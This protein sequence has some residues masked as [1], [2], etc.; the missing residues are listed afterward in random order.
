MAAAPYG[1]Q[2]PAYTLARLWYLIKHCPWDGVF[3]FD[4]CLSVYWQ[5]TGL[6]ALNMYIQR[7]VSTMDK[8]VL[9]ALK[10]LTMLGSIFLLLNHGR[11]IVSILTPVLLAIL[12]TLLLMP[13]VDYLEKKVKSRL[14]ATSIVLIPAFSAI[15]G[16][17]WWVTRMVYLEIEGFV[18]TFPTLVPA[19]QKLFNERVL[20]LVQGTRYEETFFV[21]LNEVIMR[22]IESLQAVAMRLISSGLSFIGSLPG[23]FVALMVTIILVVYLIYDKHWII[24]VAPGVGASIEKVITSIHGFIKA[25]S[26]LII[27][28]AAI[29][30]IAFNLLGIPYV[31]ILSTAI[32]VFDLLPILGPGTLLVPMI[33]WYFLIGSPWTAIMLALL[34]LV[35]IVVRQIVQPKLLSTNLGIH[36]IIAILSL[37]LGLKLFGAIGLILLPLIASIASTFP[38][39]KWLKR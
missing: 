3:Y 33:G 7:E 36:P 24:K 2:N 20:P 34:Y 15:F 13:L 19:L 16:G 28:T 35:I 12:L 9:A 17:I 4:L 18:K 5:V 1:V 30:M 10:A 11:E 27:I 38:R 37:F 26:F 22:G 25:Q 29:C 31:F 32:A 23:L 6:S 39:Y 14:L 8:R 21:I